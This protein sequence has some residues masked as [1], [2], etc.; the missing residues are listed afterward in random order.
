MAESQTTRIALLLAAAAVVRLIFFTGLTLGD[1][2]FYLS[3][4]TALSNQEGWPPL[5]L[6]W[7]T[8]L[9]IT[10]PT[11]A[12]L[13]LFGWHPI[14][15][16][17]LPFAASLAGLWLCYRIVGRVA[18]E[19]AGRIAAILYAAFPLD[20]I[21]STHLF[22]DVVVGTLA[23]GSVW[24]WV[25]GLTTRSTKALVGSGVA[26]AAGYLC[27][28][29]VFLLAPVYGAL[30]LVKGRPRAWR[31]LWFAVP[32]AAT[33]LAEALVYRQATGDPLYRWRAMAAQ[34][35][36]P[37]TLSAIAAPSSGGGFWTDPLLMLVSSHE[38]GAI[39]AL[40]V[41]LAVLALWRRPSLR[42]AAV[43]LLVGLAWLY[44]GTTIPTGWVPVQRD[45][46]YA[47]AFTVP[48]ILLVA[49][50]AVRW[51]PAWRM[52]VVSGL[53][54]LG[55]IGAGLDQRA[56]E[57]AAH[58]AF[59]TTEFADAA[60]LEPFE[61]YAARWVSGLRSP[62]VFA[63]AAD[64]GRR[65]VA[66]TA[67]TLPGAEVVPA[68]TRRYF[69]YSP[70]RRP[71]LGLKMARD[72]WLIAAEIKGTTPPGRRWLAAVLRLVPTQ[73]QRAARL[74]IP[75]QLVILERPPRHPD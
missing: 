40:A 61:Y 39:Y 17:W 25:T 31:L 4:A 5:P 32:P 68:D 2:V 16:V 46:R 7:H 41:P 34:Q 6:H 72:G 11:A 52:A 63:C 19:D 49:A 56:S 59:L 74:A 54:G 44:Y 29:T 75:P 58:R 20:V 69:V 45:P 62:V 13:T 15:F 18:G 64:A 10:V 67:R 60:S 28:E 24:L 66:E 73:E 36:N 8:R 65:S 14:V 48:A 1:D 55:L 42:W 43:W 71:D 3:A 51:P 38:F 35:A 30:W 23:A 27:R 47:A 53:V 57:L 37:E 26:F 70:S 50:Q 33:V 12:A 22:P 9:G 21:Y